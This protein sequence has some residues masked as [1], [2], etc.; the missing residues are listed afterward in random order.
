MIVLDEGATTSI[1]RTT[2]VE[3]DLAKEPDKRCSREQLLLEWPKGKDYWTIT[4]V[5]FSWVFTL[6]NSARS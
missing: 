1:G 2:L 4:K 3:W 6:M 5:M